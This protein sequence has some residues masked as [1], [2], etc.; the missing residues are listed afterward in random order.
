MTLPRYIQPN[1][2]YEVT[3]RTYN[4]TFRFLNDKKVHGIV[5]YC[6]ARALRRYNIKL[7]SYVFMSNH[8]HLMLH[9]VDGCL[10]AFLQYLNSLIARSMNALQK[11]RDKFWSGSGYVAVRPQTPEDVLRKIVYGLANPCAADLVNR[12]EEYPGVVTQLHELCGTRL[13]DTPDTFF[14]RENRAPKEKDALTLSLPVEF[15]SLST[16]QFIELVRSRLRA[17]E[18]VHQ[19]RRK[20]SKKRPAG[21]KYMNRIRLG[22]T[23]S[24]YEK[25]G[26]LRPLVACLDAAL[27]L[28]VLEVIKRFQQEYRKAL[29]RWRAGARDFLFPSGTWKMTRIA[30]VQTSPHPTPGRASA[31]SSTYAPPDEFHSRVPL[32]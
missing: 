22:A 7:Y 12:L 15:S 14:R 24:T 16:T 29:S 26:K 6:L 1:T 28:R 2:T 30:G 23:P 32:A 25:A 3:Q 13:V 17:V 27:R 9:D 8:Y 11:M 18:S 21:R 4:R 31:K 5:R 20:K 10:P 19:C